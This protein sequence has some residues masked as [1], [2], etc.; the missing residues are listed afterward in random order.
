MFPVVAGDRPAHGALEGCLPLT[1][2][3]ILFFGGCVVP[4]EGERGSFK[5]QDCG[6]TVIDR[7]YADAPLRGHDNVPTRSSKQRILSISDLGAT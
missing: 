7:G 1:L 6:I 4:E 2:S 3:E 5:I